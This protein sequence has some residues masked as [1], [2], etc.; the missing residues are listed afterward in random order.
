MKSTPFD[1]SNNRWL[2]IRQEDVATIK[3]AL[4]I[5]SDYAQL[6]SRKPE[7]TLDEKETLDKITEQAFRIAK[8]L[9]K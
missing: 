4:A 5:I 8:L 9:P 2:K 7:I 3:N 1:K 6:L